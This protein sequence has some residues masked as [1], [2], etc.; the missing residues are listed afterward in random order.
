MMRA[1]ALGLLIFAAGCSKESKDSKKDTPAAAKAEV[2][3]DGVRRFSIEA[4]DKGYSPSKISAKPSEKVILVFTR[5][6]NE[7]CL[8]QVKTPDGKLTDLPLNKATEVAV[9]MPDKGELTFTCGM[10]MEKGT[11]VADPNS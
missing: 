7:E 8:S 5:T 9:T 4:G 11:L 6:A 2:G 3:K 10:G 1:L